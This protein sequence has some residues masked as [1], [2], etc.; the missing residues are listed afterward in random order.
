MKQIFYKIIYN[1]SINFFLRSINKFILK[2]IPI[3]INLPPSGII[4]LDIDSKKIKFKTNQTNFITHLLY[5]KGYNNFEYSTIFLSL[6]SKIESF[7]D[8]G[9]NIG[10]YSLLASV[11]NPKIRIVSFEPARG[12]LYYLTENI[13]INKLENIKIE[14]IALS[15]REG[16]ITFYE[17]INKKY[18]YLE[19]N[20]GGEGNA[21]S[22]TEKTHFIETKVNTTTLDNYVQVNDVSKIDLIKMDTEGTEN[23]ILENA[24]YVL[25]KMKP[26]IICETLFDT[27]ETE[28]ENIMLKHDYEFYNHV[29]SG[30]K[31]TNTIIREKDNN[32][33]NCFFVPPSKFHLIKDFLIE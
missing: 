12:P 33:R 31:K 6:I 32:V 21:G 23:L 29:G 28:L 8:I 27:I 2:L 17:A 9:A 11:K 4:K 1:Q 26:I 20:L 3:S 25:S 7:Y 13:K 24:E 16:D 30:L 22:K 5:W 15:H 19:F 10:Y 14:A 18:R